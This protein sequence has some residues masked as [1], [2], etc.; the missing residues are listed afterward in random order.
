MVSIYSVRNIDSTRQVPFV[1][2]SLHLGK[3]D[4]VSWVGMTVCMEAVEESVSVEVSVTSSGTGSSW[5][6]GWGGSFERR[7][8]RKSPGCSVIMTRGT[9]R[10]SIS[11]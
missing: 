10:R 3:G 5:K 1:C 8:R 4:F 7:A 2:I 11:G 9:E 6:G